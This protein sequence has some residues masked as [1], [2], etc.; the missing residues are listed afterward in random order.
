M[1]ILVSELWH[2]SH[3]VRVL[4]HLSHRSASH[5]GKKHIIQLLDHFEHEGPNGTH[6][7]L[8]FEPLGDF[9]SERV[10]LCD[11]LNETY[12]DD[13]KKQCFSRADIDTLSTLL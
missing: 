6:P 4:E 7:C 9:K 2:G 1:K 10:T 11:W 5:F 3:E 13:D 8:V 12:F